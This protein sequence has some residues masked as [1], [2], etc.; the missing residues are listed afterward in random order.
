MESKYF[1]QPPLP[2][3]LLF[4]IRSIGYT[5]EMA[6]ADII[7]NSISANASCVNIYSEINPNPYFCFIDNG[8]GMNEEELKNAMLLGSFRPN[9]TNTSL[10]LGRFGMGLKSASLSQCRKFTVV[11]KQNDRILGVVFDIDLIEKNQKWILEQLSDKDFSNIPMIKHLYSLHSGT[12]VVWEHFDKI[13]NSAKDFEV[14]FR[15]YIALA[16]AH[17]EFV[18]H[19]FYDKVSIFFN[20]QRIEK[21]DPFL[22]NSYGRQQEGRALS[23]DLD[24]SIVIIT[25]YTLPYSNSL[26]YEEKQLLGNPKSI[27]DEQG[28]YIYRNERLISWGS[29]FHTEVRSELNKLARVQVDIPTSLDSIWMLDVKK[30]SAK[31]PDRIRER[32]RIAINESTNRSRGTL[33]HPGEKEL[34]E[35]YNVWQRYLSPDS[36]NVTYKL[37]RDNPILKLLQ[38]QLSSSS[39]ILLE[40]FIHQIESFLPKTN[41]H[42]DESYDLKINDVYQQTSEQLEK[43]LLDT[44]MSMSND[45][46]TREDLLNSFLKSQAYSSISKLKNQLLEQIRHE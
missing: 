24:G 40:N 38:S 22:K 34:G 33:K 27:Y 17:V 7:D 18:F 39:K 12:I 32:I 15:K 45:I 19:R 2:S 11:T 16:K 14:S 42:L 43:E 5:F 28:L 44:I 10:D 8:K 9:S 41:I 6:V 35:R 23:I 20:E 31:I 36:I 30:S 3:S 4:A 21:R 26:T 25:P 37:N 1:E 13:E 46:N 29:W